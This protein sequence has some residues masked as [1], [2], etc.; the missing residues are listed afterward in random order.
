MCLCK[1][2]GGKQFIRHYTNVY[3]LFRILGGGFKFG[4]PREDWDDLNDV[5]TLNKYGEIEQKK[6]YII[7]FCSGLGNAHHWFYYGNRSSSAQYEN[8]WD[9]IKCNIKLDRLKFEKLL[10][11]RGLELKPVK[12]AITNEEA[13]KRGHPIHEILEKALKSEEDLCLLKRSEYEIEKEWRIV[14]LKNP[15]EEE[16]APIDNFMDCIEQI[17]LLVDR[18]SL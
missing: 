11:S 18:E 3:A 10:K 14:V 1:K 7:C 6:V 9:N 13:S 4:Q 17:S 12:Y 2:E 16:P 5:F 8:C 15:D